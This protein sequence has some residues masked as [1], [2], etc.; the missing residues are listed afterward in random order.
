[1][2]RPKN[3]ISSLTEAREKAKA[4]AAQALMHRQLQAAQTRR[5][6]HE[7]KVQDDSN[8]DDT[9]TREAFDT[10]QGPPPLT[11]PHTPPPT[12][13]PTLPP[14]TPLSYRH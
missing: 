1:M 9:E 8:I 2:P 3:R 12:P 14:R 4:R 7:E 5:E 6:I 13:P 10:A 11:P